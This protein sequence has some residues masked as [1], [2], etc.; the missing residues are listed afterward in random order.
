[1]NGSRRPVIQASEKSDDFNTNAAQKLLKK[2][3]LPSLFMGE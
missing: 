3:L 1:V 2:E